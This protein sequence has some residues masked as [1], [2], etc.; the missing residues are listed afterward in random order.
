MQL[1]LVQQ[2]PGRV[3]SPGAERV[4]QRQSSCS[5]PAASDCAGRNAK[6]L[7]KFL[8]RSRNFFSDFLH[9]RRRH[10][11]DHAAFQR[12][13]PAAMGNGVLQASFYSK[14]QSRAIFLLHVLICLRNVFVQNIPCPRTIR[15]WRIIGNRRYAN[16]VSIPRSP[17]GMLIRPPICVG[18]V[19]AKK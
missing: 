5:V 1:T 13:F 12:K 7:C 19:I 4:P 15:C 10:G 9:P 8:G 2:S 16:G 11:F 17:C 18:R 14:K 6:P 3:Q